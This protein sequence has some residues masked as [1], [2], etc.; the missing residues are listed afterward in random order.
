MKKVWYALLIVAVICLVTCPDKD[1]HTEAL[2]N[3]ANDVIQKEV[4]NTADGEG[5]A[6]LGSALGAGIAN[7]AISTTL[8]VDNYFLFSVGRISWMGEEET[9]SVGILNHVFTLAN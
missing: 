7:I 9:V 3:M 1:A 2:T 8:T 6:M 5:W 4:A